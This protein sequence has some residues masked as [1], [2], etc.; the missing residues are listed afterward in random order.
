[1]RQRFAD[2]LRRLTETFGGLRRSTERL[3]DSASGLNAT[4]KRARKHDYNERMRRRPRRS[5]PRR[6]NGRLRKL[7]RK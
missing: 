6:I 7:R 3:H 2:G 5:K 1:M 4:F